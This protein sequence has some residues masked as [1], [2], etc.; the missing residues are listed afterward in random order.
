MQESTRRAKRICRRDIVRNQEANQ[1]FTHPSTVLETTNIHRKNKALASE[2]K[3]QSYSSPS[4]FNRDEMPLTQENAQ[5]MSNLDFDE[6]SESVM[7]QASS[8]WKPRR[9]S[10]IPK[11]MHLIYSQSSNNAPGRTKAGHFMRG[12]LSELQQV[13]AKLKDKE[14]RSPLPTSEQMS[15][16]HYVRGM[17]SLLQESESS[18]AGEDDSSSFGLSSSVSS[19]KKKSD[20]R[21]KDFSNSSVSSAK[22]STATGTTA[23]MTNFSRTTKN[24]F[25]SL[26]DNDEMIRLA[27]GCTGAVKKDITDDEAASTTD[28]S[29]LTVLQRKGNHFKTMEEG[30]MSGMGNVSKEKTRKTISSSLFIRD[31][32][33]RRGFSMNGKYEKSETSLMAAMAAAFPSIH[34][35]IGNNTPVELSTQQIMGTTKQMTTNNFDWKEND[36]FVIPTNLSIPCNELRKRTEHEEK[37]AESTCNSVATTCGELKH[38]RNQ[39]KKAPKSLFAGKAALKGSTLNS[40]HRVQ[41]SF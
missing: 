10:S 1:F 29:A 26:V 16:S 11:N 9:T 22:N 4:P 25:S 28:D 7:I 13:D 15:S 12:L 39:K 23:T 6:E 5:S 32:A 24:S 38:L 31:R 2:S 17:L 35:D 14:V 40:R 27:S 18:Q 37:R 41:Y 34:H 8:V 33:Q 30:G 19:L 36:N 21:N 3:M 20:G